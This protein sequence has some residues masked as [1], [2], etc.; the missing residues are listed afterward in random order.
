[1]KKILN[2]ILLITVCALSANLELSAKKA[3]GKP[4]AKSKKPGKGKMAIA[5]PMKL[6]SSA[7]ARSASAGPAPTLGQM[8]GT[9]KKQAESIGQ[10]F[11]DE[12]DKVGDD[13][14]EVFEKILEEMSKVLGHAGNAEAVN[15][16]TK[17][18]AKDLSHPGHAS[19]PAVKAAQAA[20]K[21]AGAVHAKIATQGREIGKKML[22]S[23]RSQ[24]EGI[25]RD[26]S[27]MK[28]QSIKAAPIAKS[29]VAA[30]A[31]GMQKNALDTAVA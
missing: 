7:S 8:L 5:K 30:A 24:L 11:L 3:N 27:S 28:D 14:K 6:V 10:R 23:A 20:V 4:A 16:H 2:L 21:S 26:A 13:V 25:R 31:V 12:M 15:A 22:A 17:S 1:M 18:V 29:A 19:H 9:A